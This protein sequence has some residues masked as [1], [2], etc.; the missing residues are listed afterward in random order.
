MQEAFIW[1]LRIIVKHLLEIK[2]WALKTL[3]KCGFK[4]DLVRFHKGLYALIMLPFIIVLYVHEALIIVYFELTY[5]LY[6]N[7]LVGGF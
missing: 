6:A 2:C 1:L 3:L 4:R 7:I 5:E